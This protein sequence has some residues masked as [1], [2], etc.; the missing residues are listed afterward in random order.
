M[1][2]CLLDACLLRNRLDDHA[3]DGD[4]KGLNQ[5]AVVGWQKNDAIKL[6]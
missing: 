2:N 4:F 1:L 6:D 5:D 3:M